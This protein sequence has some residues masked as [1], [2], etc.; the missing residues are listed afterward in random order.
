MEPLRG[1]VPSGMIWN[2]VIGDDPMLF[3]EVLELPGHKLEPVVVDHRL[4]VP[5]SAMYCSMLSTTAC[6]CLVLSGYSF[7]NLLK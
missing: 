5:K 2:R 6:V 7:T 1:A 4:G 3:A